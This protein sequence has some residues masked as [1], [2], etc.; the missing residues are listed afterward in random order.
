MPP[1][2]C[3]HP[4]IRLGASRNSLRNDYLKGNRTWS[5]SLGR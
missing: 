1:Q 5:F 4:R 3:L 2:L